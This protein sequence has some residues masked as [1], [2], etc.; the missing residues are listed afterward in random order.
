[1]ISFSNTYL[2]IYD[3]KR[4]KDFLYTYITNGLLTY[5]SI[6]TNQAI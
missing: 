4:Y 3:I 5:T 1:M 2:S 6:A